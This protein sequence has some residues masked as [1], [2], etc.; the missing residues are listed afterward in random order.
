MKVTPRSM[1]TKYFTYY[2][3]RGIEHVNIEVGFITVVQHLAVQNFQKKF[4][5]VEPTI[6]EKN[7]NKFNI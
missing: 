1:Q 5:N 3:K 2:K 4:R 6:F 7:V